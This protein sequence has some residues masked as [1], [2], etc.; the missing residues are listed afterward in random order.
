MQM[1]DPHGRSSH[2]FTARARHGFTVGEASVA[3]AQFPASWDTPVARHWD[4]R[5][6]TPSRGPR[7]VSVFA[8][9]RLG[10]GNIG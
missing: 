6:V 10:A 4:A 1:R 7:W 9:R 8:N 3:N 5:P 2:R